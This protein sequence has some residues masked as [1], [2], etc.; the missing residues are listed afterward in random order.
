VSRI[1]QLVVNVACNESG[2]N[3]TMRPCAVKLDAREIEVVMR[4]SMEPFFRV[5][6]APFDSLLSQCV[7]NDVILLRRSWYVLVDQTMLNG[8]MVGLES[9]LK[10]AAVS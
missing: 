5:P 7:S 4:M 9:I 1:G 6:S 2:N 8:R 10:K 3:L